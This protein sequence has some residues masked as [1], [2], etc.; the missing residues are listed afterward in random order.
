MSREMMAMS[1]LSVAVSQRGFASMGVHRMPF[2]PR[3]VVA[4]GCVR[5]GDDR[6]MAVMMRLRGGRRSRRKARRQED[7]HRRPVPD[8]H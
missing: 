8:L 2:R 4:P 3:I 7:H 6:V 1:P 5:S